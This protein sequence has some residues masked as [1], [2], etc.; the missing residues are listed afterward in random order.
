MTNKSVIKIL[1]DTIK[2]YEK[3]IKECQVLLNKSGETLEK[4]KNELKAA[5]EK[6]SFVVIECFDNDHWYL[7]TNSYGK[8][9]FPDSRRKA[10]VVAS[11]LQD[12]LI[13]DLEAVEVANA[14][15]VE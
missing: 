7:E 9:L 10:E 15:A 1:E 11:N 2:D 6:G 14:D 4:A 5:E 13:V 12:P 8:T 3:T